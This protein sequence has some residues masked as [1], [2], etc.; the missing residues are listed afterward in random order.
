M[1]WLWELKKWL[2]PEYLINLGGL[3]AVTAIIF[4]ETGLMV[5]F[6]L[7]GDS[8]LFTVG[9]LIATGHFKV[10]LAGTL[11][12]LTLAAIVGDQVGYWFGRKIGDKLFQK[13]DSLFFKKEYVYK[14]Q[15]FYD[16][17]GGKTIILGRFVPIV[18]TFAPI[19][20]GVAQFQYKTFILYNIVGGILWIFIM[21]LMGYTLGTTIPWIK[22][23]IE[24]VIMI[25]IFI[26][27]LPVFR[28]YWQERKQAREKTS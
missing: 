27:L 9:L 21:T 25:I 1:E 11:L 5:G 18:R 3:T 16:R 15:A 26:S 14:T 28:T 22:K 20:A 7:P 17:H 6:F 19:L 10:P 12:L 8:L 24:I 13:E 23:Y 4:A 2:D